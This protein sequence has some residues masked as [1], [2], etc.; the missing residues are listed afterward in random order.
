[1]D[2]ADQQFLLEHFKLELSWE[3][4]RDVLE[5]FDN[6]IDWEALHGALKRELVNQLGDLSHNHYFVYIVNSCQIW[7][8]SPYDDD[9]GARA[10]VKARE[11]VVRKLNLS[12]LTD[13]CWPVSSQS[14]AIR[15][16]EDAKS[17]GNL[18]SVAELAASSHPV[19]CLCGSL[20]VFLALQRTGNYIKGGKPIPESARLFD[21]LKE[22]HTRTCAGC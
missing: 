21:E 2:P 17:E 7:F 11:A 19:S 18:V 5:N 9:G 13:L 14:D 8:Y 6:V 3:I 12:G 15:C 10:I 1:M 16:F 20:G 4:P 22:R